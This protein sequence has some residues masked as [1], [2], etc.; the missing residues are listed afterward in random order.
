MNVNDWL[1]ERVILE[2]FAGST[3]YGTSLPTSDKDYRGIA[4]PPEDYTLG[5]ESFKQS[6]SREPDRTIYSLQRWVELALQGNP[7][8]LEILWTP[9]N[10]YVK[11]TPQGRLLIENR[12]LFLS[13]RLKARYL[14]YA[15]SQLYRLQ[16]LNKNVNNNPERLKS[17]ELYGFC[18]KNAQHL[19]RLMRTCLEIL[20]EETVHV[21]RYDAAE[22]LEIRAGKWSLDKIYAEERRLARLIDEAI[23][24]TT[25]PAKP[26]RGAVN[27]M[28]K[29][30]VRGML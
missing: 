5:I 16:R 2:A 6:V 28:V 8:I 19:V 26:N 15:Q 14:G 21:Q 25:L 12:D 3:V 22:L 27:E 10:Y 24:T 9:E 13:K 11:R 7:N 4:V 29:T 30:I 17:F 20:T 1:D 18:T 23:V